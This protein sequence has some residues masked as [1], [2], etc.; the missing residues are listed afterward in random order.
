[1]YV[2]VVAAESVPACENVMPRSSRISGRN[3]A[4]PPMVSAWN[5]WQN[6]TSVTVVTASRRLDEE[7]RGMADDMGPQ[8]NALARSDRP[9]AA[10]RFWYRDATNHSGERDVRSTSALGAEARPAARPSG[11]ARARRG[12]GPGPPQ[13]LARA[14]AAARPDLHCRVGALRLFLRAGL[15]RQHRPRGLARQGPGALQGRAR[16]ALRVLRQ[17][18]RPALCGAVPDAHVLQRPARPQH[19]RRPR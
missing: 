17:S 19:L 18:A 12:A 2:N 5:P 7:G 4:M 14:R 9:S 8:C 11:R 3:R 1:M 6:T 10:E 13:R 16:A 15:R